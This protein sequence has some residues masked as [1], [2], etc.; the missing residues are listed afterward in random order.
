M[1]ASSVL[2][3]K[4]PRLEDPAQAFFNLFSFVLWGSHGLLKCCTPKV[5][6]WALKRA[7]NIDYLRDIVEDIS[8]TAVL[9]VWS[10]HSGLVCPSVI[11]WTTRS[12]QMERDSCQEGALL[13]HP[14]PFQLQEKF[15]TFQII[16]HVSV[17]H[18]PFFPHDPAHIFP[19]S[20]LHTSHHLNRVRQQ[21]GIWEAVWW[22]AR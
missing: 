22:E 17:S 15:S 11:S 14:S 6:S 5:T 8:M 2:F 20:V 9:A 21:G 19:T 16:L 10:H 12:A 4:D 18:T 3:R 7:V 1:P 13:H